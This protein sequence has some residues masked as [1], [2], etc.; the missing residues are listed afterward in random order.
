M[1]EGGQGEKRSYRRSGSALCLRR[2]SEIDT[3]P[4]S[5]TNADTEPYAVSS[6]LT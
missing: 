6:P 5:H 3:G 1:Y 4:F 2:S